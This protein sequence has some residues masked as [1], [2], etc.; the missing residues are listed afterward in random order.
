M[1]EAR[2]Y[3]VI[4]G[5]TTE[6]FHKDRHKFQFIGGG[7]GSGKT[8]A[9]VMKVLRLARDYPGSNG[10]MARATYPKLNDTLRREFFKW[11]PPHWKKSF[12]KSDNTLELV[13]GTTINFRYIAQRSNET[14]EGTSNLLSATYDW[15]A[16]DQMEDPEI[17]HKDF[18]DL[19]GRLRG[20][21]PYAGDDPTMPTSGPRWFMFT[22][23]PTRNW[24]YRKIIRPYHDYV[25]GLW[26]PDLLC[27]RDP[28]SERPLLDNNG[29]PQPLIALYESS[30][31]ENRH[32]LAPDFLQSLEATYRG[33][34]RDRFLLGKWVGYEGLVYPQF[35][36]TNHVVA[37]KDMVRYYKQLRSK[38]QGITILESFDHGLSEPS[39]YLYSFVDEYDNVHLL[40]G[41]Y[42]PGLGIEALASRIKGIQH[43]FNAS[44]VRSFDS[45][46]IYADP[47]IFRKGNSSMLVGPS[48]SSLLAEQGIHTTRAN[49][50]LINGIAKVQAYLHIEAARQHPYS[51]RWGSSRLFVSDKLT[52]WID[53][54]QDYVWMKDKGD[55][56]EDRPRDKKNHAMDATRYLLT[57]R[58]APS[59]LIVA[60][61]VSVPMHITSWSEPPD[62]GSEYA[63]VA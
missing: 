29:K 38:S 35:D 14:G 40:D 7:Y 63:R 33:Q 54:C 27:A 3:R 31:Y 45:R 21:T 6:A 2:D 58:P 42:E 60:H 1:T 59:K 37:H 53:E 39:C 62:N 51:G 20:P 49:N 18:L 61:Q 4:K 23:N 15:I 13:N 34:M 55:E 50:A 24:L 22:A 16:V 44:A 32:N 19:V 30:T 52:W 17:S 5:S 43:E 28:D 12:N 36:M 25:N 8:T 9:L 41:F 57:S 10:L 56:L 48:V 46:D 26:H 47:A 11:M